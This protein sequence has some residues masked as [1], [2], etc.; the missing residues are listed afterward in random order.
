MRKYINIILG[1]MAALLAGGS[2]LRAQ[3]PIEV[4]YG[5]PD[6]LLEKRGQYLDTTKVVIINDSVPK[7][8]P[9]IEEDTLP[10]VPDIP[11]CK[12]GPPGGNW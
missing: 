5:V 6:E 12:Y 2:W 11:M 10:P 7:Q 8:E 3:Q 9:T 4:K 1:F